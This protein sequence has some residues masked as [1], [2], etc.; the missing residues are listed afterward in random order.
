[1][2]TVSVTLVC[3]NE[4]SV[5]NNRPAEEQPQSDCW[6]NLPCLSHP[7]GEG[8]NKRKEEIECFRSMHQGVYRRGGVGHSRGA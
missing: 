7:R 1:M 3:L 4:A 5:S 6:I 2:M 8:I